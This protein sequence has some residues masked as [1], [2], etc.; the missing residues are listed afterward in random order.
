MSLVKDKI[1]AKHEDPTL[2]VANISGNNTT[3]VAEVH[4]LKTDFVLLLKSAKVTAKIYF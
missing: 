2:H 3:A 4:S 1:E